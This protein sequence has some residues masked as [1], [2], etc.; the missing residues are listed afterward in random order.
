[1][2]LSFALTSRAVVLSFALPSPTVIFSITLP[3][4]AVHLSFTLSSPV[5]IL[6]F[7]LP[8]PA[9]NL[10][11]ALSFRVVNLSFA[12]L[13]LGVILSV[14]PTRPHLAPLSLSRLDA[15]DLTLFVNCH[16][17]FHSVQQRMQLGVYTSY[18]RHKTR[19]VVTSF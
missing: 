17:S 7:A 5:V 15:F 18:C 11:F 16:F 12:L 14:D 2:I 3:S 13:S 4:P 19:A 9:V 10:S 1:M 8:F 6:S